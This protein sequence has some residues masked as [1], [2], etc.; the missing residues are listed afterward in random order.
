M[1]MAGKNKESNARDLRTAMAQ[2]TGTDS[3]D[4]F[5]TFRGREALEII[6]DTLKHQYGSG[7]AVLQPF[8]CSTVPEAVIA[9]GLTPFYADISSSDLSI[10]PEVIGKVLEDHA[11]IRAVVA[12][13]TYG[14]INTEN[15]VRIKEAVT[16]Y[17]RVSKGT[18]SC[19]PLL[20]EDCAHCA[21]RMS[22]DEKG[23][24]LADI[25]VHSFGVEKMLPTCFGAAVWIDPELGAACPELY[26]MLT[27]SFANLPETGRRVSKSVSDYMHSYLLLLRLNLQGKQS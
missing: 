13:H 18:V 26:N 10:D 5:L 21:G 15:V 8:T 20:I 14:I 7:L 25:S 16:S 1:K 23:N 12:Q 6:C 22:T 9:G 19:R 2:R 17:H 24:P 27:G 4:W 11:D 3:K